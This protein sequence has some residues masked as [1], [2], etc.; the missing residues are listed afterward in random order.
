MS[1]KLV[2]FHHGDGHRIFINP[3]Q[4]CA[5]DYDHGTVIQTADGIGYHVSEPLFDVIEKLTFTGKGKPIMR[6]GCSTPQKL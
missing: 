5:V 1:I 6:T 3:D 2:K 4:V